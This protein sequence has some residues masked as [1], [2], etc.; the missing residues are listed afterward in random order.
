MPPLLVDWEREDA[1]AVVSLKGAARLNVLDQ[2]LLEQMGEVVSQVGNDSRVRVAMFRGDGRA[3]AAGADI[4]AMHNMSEAEARA[5]SQRGQAVFDRITHLRQP[6]IALVHGFCLG[7]GMELA[8]AC[9]IRLAAK[10]AKF[11]Q[12]EVTLGVIPGF[13]GTQRLPRIVGPPR[14][15]LLIL[16]GQLVDAEEAH[17]IGLVTDVVPLEVLEGRGRELAQ[18]LANLPSEAVAGAKRAICQGMLLA[19]DDGFTLETEIF[20]ACFATPEQKLRMSTFLEPKRPRA[21]PATS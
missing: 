12:P 8:M 18:G 4:A 20:S 1:V 3:F 5:F 6:T 14:A 2:P 9:D 15:L 19:R 16:S 17:R 13:G 7:G 21:T 10:G 11:G